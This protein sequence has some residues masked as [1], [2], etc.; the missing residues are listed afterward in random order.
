MLP[1]VV[2][3]EAKPST[4]LRHACCFKT[5]KAAD[6]MT[7]PPVREKELIYSVS[8]STSGTNCPLM[9]IMFSRPNFFIAFKASPSLSFFVS[10]S[11]TSTKSYVNN[12]EPSLTSYSFACSAFT[13]PNSTMSDSLTPNTASDVS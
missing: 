4:D 11:V 10:S 12:F 6:G 13:L 7:D 8:Q 9:I 3:A 2:G 1:L 5:S